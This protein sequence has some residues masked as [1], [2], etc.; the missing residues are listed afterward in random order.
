MN[1]HKEKCISRA[2]NTE[3]T[4]Q[5]F[6]E[7]E[8]MSNN[9]IRVAGKSPN[10]RGEICN[11]AHIQVAVKQNQK[12]QTWGLAVSQQVW[13]TLTA[14]D[15]LGQMKILKISKWVRSSGNQGWIS[16]MEASKIMWPV[17]L[18]NFNRMESSICITAQQISHLPMLTIKA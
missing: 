1:S 8:R 2:S 15:T 11:L 4:W 9:I 10:T 18:S 12:L 17:K 16:Y 3:E 5:R 13:A 14:L 7:L 6:K